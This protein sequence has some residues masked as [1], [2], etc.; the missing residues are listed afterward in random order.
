MAVVGI[1]R[2]RLLHQHGQ[3]VKALAVMRSSA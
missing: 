2:E 3:A 1:A